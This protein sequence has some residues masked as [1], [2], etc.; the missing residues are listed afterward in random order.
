MT[1]PSHEYIFT[2]P[3]EAAA[4]A[5]NHLSLDWNPLGHPPMEIYDMPHFDL[6]FYMISQSERD[7]ITPADTVKGGKSPGAD[8]IPAGYFTPPVLEIVPRMGVH[9]LDP[10]SHEFHGHGFDKTFIYGFWDGSMIFA[11]PMITLAYLQSK[12]SFTEALKLPAK[13]PKSGLYYATKYSIKHDAA[14]KEYTIALE[15]MTKR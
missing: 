7:A 1:P 14:K 13:Y 5:Y 8:Y 6:H 15:G 9:Y 12:P 2:F 4:T 10:L 11:E 3:Q